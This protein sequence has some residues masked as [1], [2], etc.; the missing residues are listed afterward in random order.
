M[1]RAPLFTDAQ[2]IAKGEEIEREKGSATPHEIHK[3]FEGRGNHS[4]VTEIWARDCEGRSAQ[5]EPA[6]ASVRSCSI[7]VVSSRA[8]SAAASFPR[9]ASRPAAMAPSGSRGHAGPDLQSACPGLLVARSP[10]ARLR[11]VPGSP[12]ILRLN[13]VHRRSR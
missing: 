9:L 10:P 12:I 3:A 5:A 1:P 8:R 6:E 11:S 13:A 4:R 7:L 2:I